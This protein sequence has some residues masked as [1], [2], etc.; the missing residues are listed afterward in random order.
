MIDDGKEKDVLTVIFNTNVSYVDR[1]VFV[2]RI[3]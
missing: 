2:S 1:P 3:G